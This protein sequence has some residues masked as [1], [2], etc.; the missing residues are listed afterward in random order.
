MKKT[1]F[2]MVTIV[3]YSFSAFAAAF[4]DPTS[5]LYFQLAESSTTQVEV[6]Y[7]SSYQGKT[8][9]T[10]PST[11]TNSGNTYSV[12]AIGGGAF[13]GCKD[14]ESVT[15]PNSI[16]RIWKAAFMNCEGLMNINIPEGVTVLGNG[17]FK[18]CL[19]LGLTPIQLPN[20][21][22]SIDAN[23]F[24]NCLFLTSLTIPASVQHI[25][26]SAFKGSGIY[27][28]SSN[29]QDNVLY[30]GNALI[31][32]S[33]SFYGDCT[34]KTGTQVVADA[35]FTGS[36]NL[37]SVYFPFA[38]PP[39]LGNAIVKSAD[40]YVPCGAEE[41][42]KAVNDGEY[43]NVVKTVSS[44]FN[45]QGISGDAT[46][47]TVRVRKSSSCVNV[48]TLV[49]VPFNGYLFKQWKDGVTDNPRAVVLTQ[50]T[51]LTAEFEKGSLLIT[52]PNDAERGTT[53]GDTTAHLND[54][55]T[56][57]ATA[58]EGFI[59]K[60]WHDGVADNPRNVTLVQD[61]TELIAIFLVAH[62]VTF[63]D[64]DKTILSTSIVADGE[65]ATAP[66]DPIRYGYKF[67]GWDKDFRFVTAD[68]T[69]IA[70][71]EAWS[72]SFENVPVNAG[73]ARKFFRDG[74]IFI[75]RGEKVYTLTG[76]EVRK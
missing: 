36:S 38:E 29:W 16:Q 49:A 46:M 74:Q 5:G 71:Y 30:I 10:I 59:F 58:K 32:S 28:S 15:L 60:Y 68:M 21:L 13:A 72:E 73:E 8:S 50:D 25:G 43:K 57:S 35:A 67:A 3:L 31:C 14:L 22:E 65:A 76:Q 19:R 39:Y 62:T 56:V 48:D 23:A 7:H 63:E 75:L 52:K 45:V 27:D 2:C 41:A 47:G 24:E 26:E 1:L 4:N 66:E 12:V 69:V 34:V 6:T 33:P 51:T 40:I 55:V 9:F 61:T 54:V 70:T 11:V 42:Y 17:A 37:Y 20:T 64:W 44:F 53:S 18:G